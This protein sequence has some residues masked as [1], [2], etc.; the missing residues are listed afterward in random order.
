MCYGVGDVSQSPKQLRTGDHPCSV[1][2]HNTRAPDTTV[3][4]FSSRCPLRAKISSMRCRFVS[5]N[6]LK[7]NVT[8]ELTKNCCRRTCKGCRGVTAFYAYHFS[9]SQLCDGCAY[10][11]SDAVV[12][13]LLNVRTN[14]VQNNVNGSTVLTWSVTQQIKTRDAQASLGYPDRCL[15]CDGRPSTPCPLQR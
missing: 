7:A 11:L 6:R 14:R 1:R 15:R 9:V 3:R 2:R 5:V 4:R 8:A 12:Q 10:L 13:K